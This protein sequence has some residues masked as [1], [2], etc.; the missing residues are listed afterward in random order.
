M[1]R[2]ALAA[3]TCC[4]AWCFTAATPAWAQGAGG[5]LPPNTLPQLRGVV[6]GQVV[7]NA[8]APGAA[9]AL[10]TINQSSL[11]AVLDWRSFNIGSAAEVLFQHE[12][13]SLASTLNRIYD[14]NPS[15]IQ[16]RLRST[17]P[18]VDGKPTAGGQVLL[19]NQNGILFDR[20]A[21]VDTQAL[22]AS[23]MNLALRNSEFC[24][25]HLVLCNSGAPLT[26]GGLTSPAFAGGYDDAGNTL[27][28]RPDGLR[29]G[30][31]GIG[32]FGPASAAPPQITSGNGGSVVLIAS[33]IDHD[34]GLITSPDGQV[35]L[36]AG[37]KAYLA[38]NTDNS[39][40]T[41]R[42]LV[43]EVEA[44][45]EGSGLNLTNLVRNAGQIT[46][47]RGNIT[48]AALAINQEGRVSAKTAVQR[49]GSVYL[50]ART[51]G[52]ADAGTV[53]LAA[54]SVT[55]V[56]PDL[57]DSATLPESSDYRP[58][59]GEIR[60]RGGVIENHGTLQAAGGRIGI[61]AAG[62]AGSAADP[63]QARVYL[64]EGSVTSAAG[65]W[66]D[67]DPAKNIASFRVT[68][69]ELKNS[70][71]QKTGLLLG[72]T[73]TV[74]LA[75]GSNILALDGYR[76]AV[77][78]TVAEKAAVGGE[79]SV[80][81]TGSLIQRA[82]A[83]V[84][85][86][87]GGYRY[88][89]SRAATTTLL[90][91]DGRIY[92]I[93]SAPQTT[94][95]AAQLDRAEFTDTRWGQATSVL[96]LT[97][98]SGNLR[99]AYVEGR[100]AGTLRLGSGAGLVL[101]GTL[102][103]GVTIGARQFE[104]APTGGTLY[105]GTGFQPLSLAL[106]D[107]PPVT[108]TYNAEGQR[109]GNVQWR[110]AATDSLGRPFTASS[111]LSAAQRDNFQLGADQVFGRATSSALGRVE[112]G[113]AN[114]EVNSDGRIV[115][116]AGVALRAE[117]GSS[118]TLRAPL[119]DLAGSV[120]L[121]AGSL[122]LAPQLENGVDLVEPGLLNLS[123]RLLVR[124]SATLSVAGAWLNNSGPG[125]A[126]VGERLPSARLTATGSLQPAT[127]GG[128]VQ[129][130][131]ADEAFQ[132]RLERGAVIN[133]SGG[134]L[135][136]AGR[137]V[138]AGRGGSIT[139][140]QGS[141]NPGSSD[142]MQAEL[143]GHAL[144]SSGSLTFNLGRAVLDGNS[145]NGTLPAD[146][147]RLL[148][149]QFS[150]GGFA[151]IAVQAANGLRVA[152]DAQI[153]VQQQNL[154]LDTQAALALPTGGD[155]R[156]VARV[157]TLPAHQRAP[158]SLTL[159]AGIGSLTVGEGAALRTDPGGSLS[160]VAGAG[161][162]IDGLLSAPG[163]R[164]TAS[165]RGTELLQT[166]ALQLGREA[167]LTVAGVFVPTPS[168]TGLVRGTL[169][170][171]GTIT[172]EAR[173]AGIRTEAGSRID[174]GGLEQPVTLTDPENAERPLGTQTL[175]GHAGT[176]LLQA[177]RGLNLEGDLNASGPGTAAGGSLAVELLRPDLQTQLPAPQRLVVAPGGVDTAPA[178][179]AGSTSSVLDGNRLQ[180]A[181][182]EK[183]RLLSEDVVELQGSSTLAFERGIRI[184]APVL[185]L[186]P[187]AQATLR[188]ATVAVGQSLGPRTLQQDAAGRNVWVRDETL[189][190][191]TAI[192]PQ[193]GDGLLRI[194]AGLVDFYGQSSLD[195]TALAR[196]E[197]QGDVR[198]IGREVNSAA[199]GQTAVFA[200]AGG[201]RTAGSLEFR[202][203]QLYPATR[204]RFEVQAGVGAP[205]STTPG[206]TSA[207]TGRYL[208][209]QGNDRPAGEVYSV[210]GQLTLQAPQIVQA[211][212]V[213]AP[214][215]TLN[216]RASER[217]ELGE[218]SLTSVSG[219]GLTVL[220]GGTL[221]GV[222]WRYAD[223][224]QTN[225]LSNPL[226]LD[227]VLPGG[228]RL[229][230][231]APDITVAGSARV[232]LR[233]G[234]NV[235]AVEFV[236]G[237]GGDNDIANAADTFAIIPKSA[238]ASVPY[239]TYQQLAGGRDVGSG[240]TLNN[241]RDGALYD[242]LDI[243]AGARVP[244]G[245]YVLLPTR[246]ATLPGAF[247][248]QL[249]TGAAFRNLQPGQAAALPTG[250]T[251]VAAHRTARGTTVRESQSVGVV[252]LPG[253]ALSRYS[254]YTLSGAQLLAA[255]AERAGTAAPAAP[256]DA[257]RLSLLDASALTLAGNFLTSGATLDGRSGSDAQIDITGPRIAI[258]SAVNP[259]AWPAGTLQIS[260][261]TLSALKA[262]VLVG[263]TRSTELAADGTP[264]TR[265]HTTATQIDVANS[266]AT[267]VELPELL[268]SARNGI[269]VAAGSLLRSTAGAADA[270]AGEGPVLRAEA[271]GALLRLS[272]QA[273]A[274]V[275]R[276]TFSAATGELDI[277][278]G[279]V[280]Q[281]G[282]ALLL[283]ATRSTRS[284]GSLRV[285]TEDGAA[286]AANAT[287]SLSLAGSR[288]TLGDT[289]G[290]NPAAGGLLLSNADLARYASLGE[291]SLRAYDALVLRGNAQ[292]GAATLGRLTLDT[293]ALVAEPVAN[294]AQAT[295]RAAEVQWLNRSSA[296]AAATSGSGLL[297]ITSTN[298]RLGE[299]SK[300]SRGFGTVSF[301]ATAGVAL[302]G[303]G[304][305]RVGG[306]FDLN[307]PLMRAEGG[308][309]QTLAALDEGTAT[310]VAGRLRAQGITAT[311][312]ADSARA[313]AALADAASP[314]PSLGGRLLLQGGSVDVNT[315]VQARAG[316]LTLQADAGA[317]TLG[318]SARL[319]AS[320][321]SVNFN[322]SVVAA[323]GGSVTLR[324]TAGDVAM[325]SGSA[326]NV[327]AAAAGG[328]AG[329]FTLLARNATLAGSLLAQAGT[330]PGAQGGT[331]RLDLGT[332][333]DFSSL[334]ALLNTGG[335]TEERQLR[336]RS[337]NLVVAA[338]D[339]V[340]ARRVAFS[341]D[342]G[343][344]D[345]LGDVGRNT[346][347][348]G[349]RV[350]LHAAEGL[351]L[352]AGSRLLA[353]GTAAGA[354]GGEVRASTQRGELAF[355]NGALIDVRAGA[356]GAPGSVIFGHT[357][358]ASGATGPIALAGTVQRGSS[359]PAAG[360]GTGTVTADTPR[361]S[362]DLELTRVYSGTQVPTLL[363]A[364][365]LA[366]WAADHQ[367][368]INSLPSS[369][370]ATALAAMQDETGT[371]AG[372]RVTG[373]TELRADGALTLDANWNLT[374]DT[375]LAGGL[376]GTLTVRAAGGLRLQQTIGA[377]NTPNLPA[378]TANVVANNNINVANHAIRAGD[379][380]HIRLAAGADLGAADPLAVVAPP[381]N[382][383]GTGAPAAGRPDLVL[384]NALAGVRT[385]TGRIDLAAAGDI[386]LDNA[387]SAIYTAGR[388]GAADSAVNGNNRWAVDGGGISLRAGGSVLGP[389]GVP[390]LWVTDWLRRLRQTAN[391]FVRDGFLTDWWSYRPRF[392]QGVATL[393]GG[394]IDVQAGADVRDL[395][396]ALP[397]SGRT[398]G[399]DAARTVEVTGGGDLSV[400]A[401]GSIDGASF[402]LGRGSGV[403]TA[404][405]SIGRSEAV[406]G[407]LMGAS[408]GATPEEASL[409]LV[410]GTGAVLQSVDNP[411]FLG[412]NGGA[413]ATGPSFHPTNPATASPSSVATTFFT[414]TG[415]SAVTVASKSGDVQVLGRLARA[416]D[417][418]RSITTFNNQNLPGG[419]T[420]F[421]AS[422][423]L[424]ALGGDVLGPDA[425]VAAGGQAS[426]FIKTWPSP[427][428]SL[429]ALA[430]GSVRELGVEVSALSPLALVTP[431][432][433]FEGARV[434]NVPF[435]F[436][437]TGAK[438]TLE[439]K[440][441]TLG[442][443]TERSVTLPV[444]LVAQTEAA[445]GLSFD[446]QALNGSYIND[447]RT[448]LV[449]P[450]RSRVRA[451]QDLLNPNLQLQNLAEGDVSEVRAVRGKLAKSGVGTGGIEIAG[452]GRLLV[453]AGGDI[454]LGDSVVAAN[455]VIVGGL[456]ATGN[457]RNALLS[458]ADSA[459]LTVIAGVAADVNLAQMDRTYARVLELNRASD[460]ISSLY[461]QLALEL[462]SEAGRTA[463]LAAGSVA[464][465]VA[466]NPAFERLATLDQ[467]AP[468]A[469]PAYQALLREDRLPLAG[470][471]AR[472]AAALLA[473]LAREED[474]AA[475]TRSTGLADYL[476][477]SSAAT[478]NAALD[479]ATRSRYIELAERYPQLYSGAVLRRANGAR[480]TGTGPLVFDAMLEEVVQSL[481]GPTQGRS[482]NI[483]SFQT[484]VQT[485]GGSDI[486]L[487]APAGNIVVGL[488]TPN[489]ARPVGIITTQGGAVKSVLS[490]NFS[491]NQGKL[492]TAQ[493]G[494]ILVYSAQGSID[495]GRGAKTSLST[496]A[497]QRRPILDGEGNQIGVEVVI[498]A[499]ASGSGIQTLSSDPDGLGPATAPPAGDIFLFAPAGKIDA[500]EAGIRSSGNI[501]VNAQVVLNASDIKAAGSSQGVPQVPTGSLASTLAAAGANPQAATQGEDKATQAAAQAAR[502]A[503]ASRQAPRPTVL[504]VEVLGFGDKNCREDDREC[505]AK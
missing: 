293:P 122:V 64:G 20:G 220:Y 30:N 260:S 412:L 228:K 144:A 361:A 424:V 90:G 269:T 447:T 134:A 440:P 84:D 152:D 371:A 376:P 463:V 259:S 497:P 393:A 300:A 261:S 438:V 301:T 109:I 116:P 396:L 172:L 496:P 266:A 281:A 17:G 145:A 212:T 216:L 279:A 404:G 369:P 176:L 432:T 427:T 290:L 67:V 480:L 211:G 479:A 42:G 270:E 420:A 52:N 233:G 362:V 439:L 328:T 409:R 199:A 126:A 35:V 180:A 45:K 108:V 138:S 392:Q 249:Q 449:L 47:D 378:T 470:A 320:G 75:A 115:L 61:E 114:V 453:Q 394:D 486:D 284:A 446:I 72:A 46:A 499:S 196:I 24:G 256:W 373:A 366:T 407:Y 60:A 240:F 99:E 97:L 208:L 264:T 469:L 250:E 188:A 428:A 149:G 129:L 430:T 471:A 448:A 254:D 414:Y 170:G 416:S 120:Q 345:V 267:P 210:A 426:N 475:L 278:T 349:A 359:T 119:L 65:V 54:G 273:Q 251:V 458:S 350:A 167:A 161:L 73:V 381:A 135:L 466:R 124:G 131:L 232:D 49:N 317:L 22:L 194:E 467:Q 410:A 408:S 268:L 85:V 239:D 226:L 363:G 191:T 473:L 121:P 235:Q 348:G 437:N 459:R 112:T 37:S 77:P 173:Q 298:L 217:L 247:L 244:A 128:N 401:G 255:R 43:V 242:S 441:I 319:D 299:G 205:A 163:G 218:N 291:L 485:L 245:E 74:D 88:A 457:T 28:L 224:P 478:G 370:L 308:A 294:S 505:F 454:D 166:P 306:S 82:G 330:A 147:T 315:E 435:D 283:D 352:A 27:A 19:I 107:R 411:T 417:D 171:G 351:R 275:D 252:V 157:Q 34:A 236:P 365:Q 476:Q 490:G 395:L 179:G 70:P 214:Q 346:E 91:V 127:A 50:S 456:V 106:V 13:G 436:F 184:D 399:R 40:L 227:A 263:G 18:M 86:S 405:A 201:L 292:V 325:Q 48:I 123:E 318:S 83:T 241:P 136:D 140:A 160:L 189:P 321:D 71:D 443:I 468:E 380:W 26:Q 286:G 66:S 113:F 387:A 2:V 500:G 277:A 464:D 334:N 295:L 451:G 221:D 69:N 146:T 356:A 209:V 452:P 8:P 182:F 202:A 229:D 213:R 347:E 272:S 103:G 390:D 231:N 377:L 423:A 343:R 397:T 11:R 9:A 178:T 76:G 385:G 58:Y 21:R 4:G 150:E 258:V 400:A 483:F 386:R 101:D 433:N 465:L 25:G 104:R 10:M 165:L 187:G 3:A 421:P 331:A 14:A 450:A 391:D 455:G 215:G 207:T 494:D 287:G 329:S 502:Q 237:N 68:S 223:G 169:F 344:I 271:S 44:H 402:L 276:G 253:S 33:R 491:I 105:V 324:A 38:V 311:A 111:A 383:T 445:A 337:G 305:L 81:S 481:V 5:T 230:M 222:Q 55:E 444:G 130:R 398:S 304:A 340:D 367:G 341:A 388:I 434:Q 382:A 403:V 186:A 200:Q 289:A 102:N 379:T 159:G 190:Q 495:A 238:L 158:A 193:P 474:V 142:W 472:D 234:G 297:S 63:A 246:F 413:G 168:D 326:V 257:G 206:T 415:N 62:A 143:Q 422:L 303:Q 360:T 6:A 342:A 198:F 310:P 155:L 98:A 185:R 425:G 302:Q 274:S 322:G 162:V 333:A 195:G 118:L 461:A 316:S 41:L 36:A 132:T 1:R 285:G 87:G 151:S 15:V 79:I 313:Q 93:A 78:R 80:A 53:R 96:N 57:Q 501:L 314:L 312:A 462:E 504:T 243:G 372:T 354:R 133:A 477:N 418:W 164:I 154:V 148:A 332:L 358:D 336:L 117:A 389:A 368:F 177:Q 125:G 29:P 175:A 100:A 482:G 357:R 7:V 323:D 92:D 262:S 355:D 181:G 431:T 203:S 488:T 59:R 197:S 23:T 56:M 31:I 174:V 419:S 492:L 406:Q 139:L 225:N 51:L 282:N 489:A 374:A 288:V 110:Q 204:T 265:I 280:L 498:P 39:D 156:S 384:A 16:G 442:R 137:R 89:D 335:F 503:A 364:A 95:F 296:S 248:V 339:D 487:W 353:A 327:S 338:T 12:Q 141:L 484:S 94:R 192:A 309:N 32:S 153:S 375:W 493:G 307:T 460:R 219:D 183:L 429:A